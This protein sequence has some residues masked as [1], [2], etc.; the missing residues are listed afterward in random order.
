M[1]SLNFHSLHSMLCQKQVFLLYIS[2]FLYTYLLIPELDR[3]HLVT[4]SYSPNRKSLQSVTVKNH[5]GPVGFRSRIFGFVRDFFDFSNVREMFDFLFRAESSK[6]DPKKQ[7]KMILILI[8]VIILIDHDFPF[9]G[10]D[11]LFSVQINY[12]FTKFYVLILMI[13]LVQHSYTQPA[14]RQVFSKKLR[15]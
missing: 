2:C 11:C 5:S 4:A 1:N 3:S 8:N 15:L 12:Y 14:A 6:E 13:S 7:L 9:A 10:K